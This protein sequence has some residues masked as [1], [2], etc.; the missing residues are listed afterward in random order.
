MHTAREA[1]K[2]FPSLGS[3]IR[4]IPVLPF[5]ASRCA[6]RFVTPSSHRNGHVAVRWRRWLPHM[7]TMLAS[8][9]TALEKLR[10][11]EQTASIR[12]GCGFSAQLARRP[13]DRCR[14]PVA[15]ERLAVASATRSPNHLLQIARAGE[16]QSKHG[17]DIQVLFVREK[18]EKA[19]HR[20]MVAWWPRA[21]LKASSCTTLGSTIRGAN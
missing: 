11:S 14:N 7:S 20:G 10:R 15:A 9:E 17:F 3:A 16:V 18:D 13:R 12:S 1:V 5:E 8:E 21:V 19:D 4:F 6:E 2:N